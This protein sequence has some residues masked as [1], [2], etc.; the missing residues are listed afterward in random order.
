MANSMADYERA[1]APHKKELFGKLLASLPETDAVV[2]E[3][4]MGSF[5]NA[6][7]LAATDAAS[8]QRMDIVG[9]DPNDSMEAYAQ[10]SARRAGLLEQGHSVRVVHGVG[11]AL[12]LKN[13]VADAVVCTLTLCS[14]VEPERVM[15]EVR[16]VSPWPPRSSY[17]PTLHSSTTHPPRTPT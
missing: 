4:G 5:P 13:R 11:E 9:I 6:P 8:P 15:A 16:R 12:P 2:V 3:L 10:R 7:Y 14:V 1:V 17:H